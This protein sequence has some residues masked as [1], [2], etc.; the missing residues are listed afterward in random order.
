MISGVLRKKAIEFANAFRET[1]EFKHFSQCNKKLREN[2]EAQRKLQRFA[3][4]ERQLVEQQQTGQMLDQNLIQE[5][6]FLQR[7]INEIN[8]VKALLE[9]Q[10]VMNNLLKEVNELILT[11]IENQE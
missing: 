9:S 6:K 5:L 3:E 7:D 1:D 11:T 4:L 8:D 10:M 2:T